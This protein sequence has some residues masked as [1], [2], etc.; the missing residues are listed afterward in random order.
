MSCRKALP[1][2]NELEVSRC[3]GVGIFL[4]CYFIK[5]PACSLLLE[6]LLGQHCVVIFILGKRRGDQSIRG[7]CELHLGEPGSGIHISRSFS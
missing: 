7:L 2:D 4:G 5:F 1:C 3:I 6:I